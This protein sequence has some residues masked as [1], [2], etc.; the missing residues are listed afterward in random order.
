MAAIR[1]I[2][3]SCNSEGDTCIVQFSTLDEAVHVAKLAADMIKDR[4][5]CWRRSKSP[6]IKATKTDASTRPSLIRRHP[7]SSYHIVV[8]VSARLIP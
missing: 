3:A 6:A 1:T 4:Q 8:H 2:L 7:Q 5:S